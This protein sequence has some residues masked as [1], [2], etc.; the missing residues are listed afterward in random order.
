MI[1]K[2]ISSIKLLYSL[3]DMYIQS[4]KYTVYS[5]VQIITKTLCFNFFASLFLFMS[6]ILKLICVMNT[7]TYAISFIVC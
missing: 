6:I 5:K 4:N 7:F 1:K 3:N 2:I